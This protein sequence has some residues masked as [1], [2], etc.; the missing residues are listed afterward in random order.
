MEKWWR[1]EVIYQ[2]YPM[3]F[4]DTNGDG[5][6]DIP[7]IISKL[8]YL[9]SLGVGVLWLSPV[10]RSPNEDNGYD[11]SDYLDIDPRYGTLA[12]MDRLIAEAKARGI[13]IIMDLVVNHTSSEH[14]W[15]Q[16]SRE[17]IEPYTD[18][19]I[20][21]KGKG[22]RKPNN[23]SGFFGGSVWE[24]DDLRQEY[25]LHL[26]AKGQP[27]L[28]YYNPV[29]IA[30]VK[31]L[32]RFWLDRGVSGFRCDVINILY[33]DSLKNGRPLPALCG[34]E[35]YL[36]TDG[37]HRI[38]QELRR[39]VLSQYD[40]FTV[41]ECVLITPK[42]AKDLTHENRGKLDMVFSFEH[43]DADN[44]LIKWF[45]RRFRPKRLYKA[46]AKWQKELE[47]N[48]I[49]L[50]NHDQPRSV[51]RF[52]ASGEYYDR[53][54]KA[55]AVLLMT[56]RGTPFVF[57]GEELGMTNFDFT[58]MDQIMDV[59]SHNVDKVLKK[60]G[61]SAKVRWRK[62]RYA[63]RDN[64]RTPMQW[65]GRDGAGFTSG[66]PW[67]GI[68][69]N[70]VTINAEDEDKNPD[71][72]LNFYRR[73]TAF[74]NESEALKSGSFRCTIMNNRVFAF[75]RRVKDDALGIAV[76]LSPKTVN[77]PSVGKVLLSNT[78]REVMDCQLQPYEAVIMQR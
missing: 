73:L 32:M 61:F 56:L 9:K 8:D 69:S 31:K 26:F 57:Q 46:F 40:C 20:W 25:Y 29:V 2:I 24:Y 17:R 71:S 41:G 66:T 27:D 14:E 47:W 77:L 49:Y 33:K 7:G 38:L 5:V 65:N 63:S 30:E 64:A 74:R 70:H 53:S 37:T 60:M 52:G 10:Y 16:K 12:D 19:Y 39:D 42:V 36:S 6:G 58:S 43:M 68:N 78:G 13:R 45:H 51:S 62:M 35:H 3:S 1:D 22:K 59:E 55:L 54:C 50:E 67:L 75:E 18:Y 76:N 23:W 44:I 48:T 28:N 11:I 21:R 15:F 72:V 34:A 4:C